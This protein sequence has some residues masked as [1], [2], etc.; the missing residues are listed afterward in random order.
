MS[1]TGD[2]PTTSRHWSTVLLPFGLAGIVLWGVMVTRAPRPAPQDVLQLSTGW[3]DESSCIE[4]HE[5]AREFFDTG[6][7]R[8][9]TRATAPEVKSLFESLV[10]DPRN[11]ERQISL[12]W[13]DQG[14]QVT[15]EGE[16]GFSHVRLGWCFGSGNHARTWVGTL[17][18]SQGMSDLLEFRWTWFH[19]TGGFDL[20]PG[21]EERPA[22]GY[23]S[24][25]GL[26]FDQ[27]K[28]RRCFG[29]HSTVLPL[30]QGQIREAEIHTGVTCQRCHGPRAEHVTSEGHLTT[31]IRIPETR[32]ESVKRC[33]E[34]HRSAEEQPA[35]TIRPG[36]PNIV[37]FQPI[38]LSQSACYLRSDMSCLTCHD[39]HRTLKSQDSRGDWQC[40]QCH[41]NQGTDRPLCSQGSTKDCISC[42]MPK[43]S[44]ERPVQFTD[45]WIRRPSLGGAP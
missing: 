28:A 27:P 23:Y 18:D 11:S 3:A 41:D 16:E 37:R 24:Q 8:T 38:G 32:E 26:L 36:N 45:H 35:D 20:T 19:Q 14:C 9:L 1:T 43:V 30:E 42:H 13:N 2:S 25:L 6:H 34:C 33:A 15:R 44:M 10:Q 7:A 17:P 40:V 31:A 22:A 5:Q 39:P 12:S 4:C 29:C 21:H